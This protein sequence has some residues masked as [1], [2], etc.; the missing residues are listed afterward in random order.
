MGDCKVVKSVVGALPK[1]IRDNKIQNYYDF[2]PSWVFR[3]SDKEYWTYSNNDFWNDILP[4]LKDFEGR[5]WNEILQMSKKSNH[6]ISN[7]ESF[8]KVAIKRLNELRIEADSIISLR[9][10]GNHRLYGYVIDTAFHILWYDVDHGDNSTCV[11][12]SRLKNT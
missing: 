9:L 3:D 8:N 4:K 6:R 10:S 11:C 12:R 7:T 5:S 1:Q 2:Y